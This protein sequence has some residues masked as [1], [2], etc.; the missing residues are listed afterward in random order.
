[1]KNLSRL[2][3]ACMLISVIACKKKNKDE[4]PDNNGGGT[5]AENVEVLQGTIDSDLVLDINKKYLLKGYVYV[6]A[7]AKLTIPAGMVIKGDQATKATLIIERGA[8]IH[9]EGTVTNPIVF[10]S[11]KPAGQRAPGDWGGIIILGH[12]Y[13][14]QPG[15]PIVE[16]GVDRPFGVATTFSSNAAADASAAANDNS[17][18]FRYVR[19]EFSGIA[20]STDNEING[21]TMAG[22]GAG[23]QIDHVQISYGGDDAFEWF[24]GNV[25]GKYLI[26]LATIDDDFDT[27]F[28]YSGNVQYGLIIRDPNL[29]DIS[30]TSSTNGFE[31][32][33]DATGSNSFPQ[34]RGQFAN[35]TVYGPLATSSSSLTT[36][37]ND[38]KNALRIRRNSS[39]SVYNSVFMGFP[40]G[41]LIDNSGTTPTT[42]NLGDNVSSGSLFFRGNVISGIKTAADTLKYTPNGASFTKA[43]LDTWYNAGSNKAYT[44]NT[45]LGLPAVQ[46]SAAFPVAPQFVPTAG[47]VLLSGGVTLPTVFE[48]NTYRGAFNTQDWTAG[49]S[50]FDPQNTNYG[51]AY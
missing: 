39:I 17:G 30:G 3:I 36:G 50:N 21:L 28:G 29:S 35:V 23:T 13:E 6:Q 51:P 2:L 18:V 33:G 20:L 38:F 27:D 44:E 37:G 32:D 9:A 14:N 25:D 34:T 4:D 49:W 11:N 46:G 5:P 15:S 48:S 31:S 47:S 19:I 22:V 43:D 41:L 10:T 8:K 16:G 7:P 42:N 40:A 45:S 1:M 24:G 26:S 12:G